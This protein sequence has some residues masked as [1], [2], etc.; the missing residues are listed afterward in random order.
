MRNRE[1]CWLLIGAVALGASLAGHAAQLAVES[2]HLFGSARALYSHSL[3]TPLA[4]LL[5]GALIL[6]A[7][8]IGR[9]ILEGVRDQ[10]EDADWLV[11]A[12][13]A[14][15]QI[16]P[17]R[18]IALIIGLQLG[19]LTLGE[20]TE[21]TL[22]SY[23]SIGL[24]AIFG[25]GHFTAPFVH[26]AIGMLAAWL[27]L[28]FART[29]CT[30]VVDLARFALSVIAWVRRPSRVHCAPTLRTLTLRSESPAPPLLA[31][32]IASRPPPAATALV[33]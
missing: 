25:P 22:S 31:R 27:L 24:G 23:N 28:A 17:G 4:Y 2:A 16:A 5:F 9:G 12:L 21:Q 7:L 3:Q 20:L 33:A 14:V 1:V 26:A 19:S 32:H 6:A 10:F 13:H 8:L 11:P 15:A 30:R 18:L 29:V